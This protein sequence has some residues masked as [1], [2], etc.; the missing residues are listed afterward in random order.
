MKLLLQILVL[1]TIVIFSTSSTLQYSMA[2]FF[3]MDN[4]AVSDDFSEDSSGDGSG[5][6]DYV[7]ENEFEVE[8]HNGLPDIGLD[9]VLRNVDDDGEET[10]TR[11]FDNIRIGETVIYYAYEGDWLRALRA[12][13]DEIVEDIEIERRQPR[14]TISHDSMHSEL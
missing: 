14:Y 5:D 10:W 6:E 1:P 8:L 13:T 9:I 4:P 12:G 11:V 7:D 3:D 2:F